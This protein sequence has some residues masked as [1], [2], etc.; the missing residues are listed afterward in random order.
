MKKTAAYV[1]VT[2]AHCLKAGD[3]VVL[4]G[5]IGGPQR[6]WWCPRFAWTWWMSLPRNQKQLTVI[7]ADRNTFTVKT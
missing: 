2:G 7:H 5:F 6:P 1:T 4:S 3:R